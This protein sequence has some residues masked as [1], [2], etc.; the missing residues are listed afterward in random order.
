M[1]PEQYIALRASQG[2]SKTEAVRE[3]AELCGTRN[4]STVWNWLNGTNTPKPAICRLI[5][6]WTLLSPEQRAQIQG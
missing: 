4:L 1:T 6:A 2:I 5:H 3:L